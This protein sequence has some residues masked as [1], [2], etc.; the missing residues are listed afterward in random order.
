M[1]K[2]TTPGAGTYQPSHARMMD[3]IKRARVEIRIR[4]PRQT[5]SLR[6]TVELGEQLSEALDPLPADRELP[7]CKNDQERAARMQHFRREAAQHVADQLT[8]FLMEKFTAQDPI[9]GYSPEEWAQIN[10]A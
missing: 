1:P 10:R 4:L 7:W 9:Q 2:P 5:V 6:Y 3:E 8:K